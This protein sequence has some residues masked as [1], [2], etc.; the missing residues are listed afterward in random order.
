[1]FIKPRLSARAC[2]VASVSGVAIGLGLGLAL[3]AGAVV[4]D[5]PPPGAVQ[6]GQDALP[7]ANAAIAVQ[8]AIAASPAPTVSPR[9]L[10]C[11]T[12][13]VYYE[14]RGEAPAGQAAV[15]QVVLN[16]VGQARFGTSVCGVVYEGARSRSCQFSFA[17]RGGPHGRHEVAAW[18]R[19]RSVAAR[20][21]S[22]YVMTEV[23]HATYFHVASLGAVWGPHMTR[24]AHVGHHIFYS[25]GGR[26]DLAQAYRML[27]AS[28]KATA[29]AAEALRGPEKPAP[30]TTAA[31]QTTAAPSTPAAA[32]AAPTAS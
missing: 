18:S 28:S 26:R 11:L 23:G 10:E 1:L 15:A 8:Q 13:A 24:V 27:E 7:A 32:S 20:A 22:G 5:T 17:C 12:A 9:E 21:L 31:V 6:A 25:P 29:P 2:F 14:A 19:A 3:V 16:R 30:A 4:A